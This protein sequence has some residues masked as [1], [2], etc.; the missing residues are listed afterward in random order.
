MIVELQFF[1]NSFLIHNYIPADFLEGV[2]I[3]RAK[4]KKGDV[5]STN[6]YREVMI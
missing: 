5:R 4:D 1:L 2:I 6:K 3:P